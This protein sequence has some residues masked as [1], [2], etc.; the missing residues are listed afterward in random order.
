MKK[1][2]QN[3]KAIAVD[4]ALSAF[5]DN[6]SM[7]W[8]LNPRYPKTKAMKA[9]CEHCVDMGIKKNGAFISDDDCCICLIFEHDAGI[10][11]LEAF[12]LNYKFINDCCGWSKVW[13]VIKRNKLIKQKR[14]K[15]PHL[16]CLLLASNKKAGNKSV[17][18]V[19]NFMFALSE[20][21]QMP[22]LAETALMQ[23]KRVYE[24]Y[25]FHTYDECLIP[26]SDV[27]L[28]LMKRDLK[29]TD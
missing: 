4:I 8:F 21:K 23:N 16:Y 7:N 6:P 27:H 20:Q 10:G 12:F 14:L 13:R 24:Y 28:W 18:E 17:I 3:N 29:K 22:I 11:N 9:L 26:D 15:T 1:I 2:N 25:G 5:M 19:K